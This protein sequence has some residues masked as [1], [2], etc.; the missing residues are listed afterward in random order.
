MAG[1]DWL[2]VL[3]ADGTVL[4][5]SPREAKTTAAS[6]L[7]TRGFR[8]AI[9]TRTLVYGDVTTVDGVAML[10]A[11]QPYTAGDETRVPVVPSA[12][13]EIAAVLRSAL[14][15]TGS[16]AYMVDSAGAT[17]V[18]PSTKLDPQ[19]AAAARTTKRGVT[20]RGDY[21]LSLNVRSTTWRVVIATPRAELLA[22][23]KET[24]RVSWLIF[25]GFAA[26]VT[27][28]IAIGTVTLRSSARLAHARLHDTLTGLPN[29][30]LFLERAEVAMAQKQP[31][32]A[33]FLDLDGFKPV[34]D[35]YGHAAGDE[36][37]VQVGR[38]LKAATRQQDLVSR[39]GGDE[40]LVLCRGDADAVAERIRHEL[41]Q[42]F[43]VDGHT[44]RIGVSIGIA[45]RTQH[46][47]SADTLIHNADLALY[48]A[49]RGGRGR[50]E[51]FASV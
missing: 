35:T 3:G 38:R 1:V 31:V 8:L 11:F 42:P 22:P 40:F 27:L 6:L 34:N 39:F 43:D 36:L 5:A 29:R 24:T 33:L 9:S 14:D 23:V 26:A 46:T 50:I 18:A 2:A 32:A 47:D 12:A 16:R 13:S 19:L 30:A 49:K 17:I 51:R 44:V 7:T 4:G 48:E 15:V 45:T 41:S 10:Y 20:A 25:A 37:L 21:Y 28:I